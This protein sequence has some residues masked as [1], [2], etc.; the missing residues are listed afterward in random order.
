MASEQSTFVS[1]LVVSAAIALALA[2]FAWRRRPAPGSSPLAVAMLALAVWSLCYALELATDGLPAKL[3]WS[4]LGYIGILI[5]PVALLVFVLQYTGTRRRPPRY[6]ALVLAVEPLLVTF[7]LWTNAGQALFYSGVELKAFGDGTRLALTYGPLFWA[8]AL[9]TYLVL[10]LSTGIVLAALR[11]A[12]QPYRAQGS[13][14]LAAFLVL[15]AANLLYISGVSPFPHLDLT[16]IAFTLA[17]ILII[18]AIFRFRFLELLPVA[19]AAIIDSIGDGVIVLDRQNRVVRLNLVGQQMTGW[20][21]REAIGRPAREVLAGWPDVLDRFG[22]IPEAHAELLLRTARDTCERYYDMRITPL[23]D[24]RQQLIGRVVTMRD[25]DDRK[26]SEEALRKSEARN[27]AYIEAIPDLIFVFDAHGVYRDVKADK[28]ELLVAP[29]EALLGKSVYD[30]LPPEVALHTMQGIEKALATR[31]IQQFDYHLTLLPDHDSHYFEARLSAGPEDS[32]VVLVRDITTRV[33]TEAALRRR[34]DELTALHA[35]TVE[36]TAAH[37]LPDLLN[38]IVERAASLLHAKAGGLYLCEPEQEQLRCVVSYRTLCDYTGV[39]LRYGEGAAGI[40]ARTGQ[41]LLIED[42]RTWPHRADVYQRDQPFVRVLY[43][44]MTWQGQVIGTIDVLNGADQ[45]PFREADLELLSLFA[46]QAALAVINARLYDEIRGHAADLERRVAE[47]TAELSETAARLEVA[48]ASLR[49]AAEQLRELDRLKSQFVSNVTHEL[50]TPLTNIKT[51]LYLLDR[52]KPEK[53]EGYMATLGREVDLL[54][55]LIED[56]LDLSR[57]DLGKARPSV[58]PVDI[59]RWLEVLAADRSPLIAA[60]GLRLEVCA[61]PDVPPVLTDERMLTQVLT[62]LMT[63]AM[64]YTPAGG[65]VQLC[66]ELRDD[67]GANWVVVLVSDTGPGIAPEEQERVFERFYRGA[68][69]R[70][71]GAPGTGLGLAICRELA[72]RLGGRITLASQPGQGSTFAVW[73]PCEA[74]SVL[75]GATPG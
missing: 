48:N 24:G 75:C 33:A 73:L 68:A 34:A 61:T 23:R 26:R 5:V 50:R 32:V 41:P 31:A 16:P 14:L 4:R 53:R 2:F 71:G 62:N 17:G 20:T 36:L 7:L 28:A 65:R 63:N 13:V 43:V 3:L 70:A 59:N 46:Q 74:A 47:R 58:L 18:W 12:D 66:T 19:G 35:T 57:M 6:V 49:L 67:A 64:N 22:K 69:A 45:P 51:Y 9:Y 38:T 37:A 25:I 15:W 27:R 42:Y 56:V 1:L 52:G 8:H 10:A 60:R 40:V 21:E 30:V 72:T 39:V 55:R 11:R 54:Q 44:P 29:P